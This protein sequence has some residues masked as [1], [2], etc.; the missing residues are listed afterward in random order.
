MKH[1]LNFSLFRLNSVLS[2]VLFLAKSAC[3][4][5]ALISHNAVRDKKK[6]QFTSN[7]MFAPNFLEICTDFSP[8][9]IIRSF[10]PCSSYRH[11]VHRT[12]KS[13]L[14][15]TNLILEQ[16]LHIYMKLGTHMSL[17]EISLWNIGDVMTTRWVMWQ[18]R[19]SSHGCVVHLF[20]VLSFLGIVVGVH[21]G[22][23]CVSKV[24]DIGADYH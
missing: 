18:S 4:P 3:C 24:S 13:P 23:P 11:P 2:W 6:K 12:A 10:R 1:H 16:L 5:T 22:K 7:E 15:T 8:T 17:S 14:Q 19:D 20:R 9:E 21:C